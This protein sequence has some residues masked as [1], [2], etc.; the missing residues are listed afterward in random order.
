M[1]FFFFS[2]Y[3]LLLVVVVVVVVGVA[4]GRGDCGWCCGCFLG[5]GIYYFIIVNILFYC[6]ILFYCVES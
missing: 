4:N 6:D 2:C 1:F 5:S 3:G